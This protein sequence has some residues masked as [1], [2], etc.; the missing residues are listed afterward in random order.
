[1]R[2]PL[3]Y[4]PPPRVARF[5]ACVCCCTPGAIRPRSRKLRPFS[6]SSTI[7]V[8]STTCPIAA[9]RVSTSGDC[10]WTV[11]DSSINPM[12]NA[13]SMRAFW[14]TCRMKSLR[15]SVLKPC[16]SALIR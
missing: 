2:A 3:M 16:S 13:K 4:R 6:G 5:D 9:S 11:I 1:M 10:P 15:S 7:F 8:C 12:L 14:L